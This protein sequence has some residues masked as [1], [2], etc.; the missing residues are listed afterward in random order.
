MFVYGPYEKNNAKGMGLYFLEWISIILVMSLAFM[1]MSGG[2]LSLLSATMLACAGALLY[3]VIKVIIKAIGEKK[4]ESPL[5]HRIIG[6]V[7]LVCSIAVIPFAFDGIT[8]AAVDTITAEAPFSLWALL[9]G[10]VTIVVIMVCERKGT[11]LMKVFS[12]IIGMIAGSALAAIISVV[13][14]GDT[15]SRMVLIDFSVL[16]NL[17]VL[18]SSQPGLSEAISE[19]ASMGLF[20]I[21]SCLVYMLSIIFTIIELHNSEKLESG[22]RSSRKG[23]ILRS[24]I[25]IISAALMILIMSV[26][27]V[28]VILGGILACAL[29]GTIIG[30]A[31]MSIITGFDSMTNKG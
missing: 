7:I 13:G 12:P 25:I 31:A 11:Q 26:K 21:I 18:A 22:R 15:N 24:V 28:A 6:V 8:S 2:D 10:I 4:L 17:E 19:I 29:G 30:T 9:S 14:S 1:T 5:A 23:M 20:N 3:L 16:D 27:P